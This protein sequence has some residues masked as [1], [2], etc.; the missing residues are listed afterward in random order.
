MPSLR[1]AMKQ[2][3]CHYA[4]MSRL[5]KEALSG[6][7]RWMDEWLECVQQ[8]LQSRYAL[9]CHPSLPT[10]IGALHLIRKGEREVE[11]VAAACICVACKMA[12]LYFRPSRSGLNKAGGSRG[13]SHVDNFE[14]WLSN[15]FVLQ[16]PGRG[17]GRDSN[18]S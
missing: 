2:M 9:P 5:E 13:R 8:K 7:M 6:R 1:A 14:W 17:P 16:M 10:V 3:A 18:I 12:Q 4:R 15:S 11:R